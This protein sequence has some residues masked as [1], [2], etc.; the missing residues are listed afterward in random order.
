VDI[1][2]LLL[3]LAFMYAPL[4]RPPMEQIGPNLY[5]GSDPTMREICA[6]HEK[7]FKTIISIRTNA[8]DK[9]RKLCEKLGMRWVNIKTGVFLLPTDDQFDQFRAIIN[10]PENRPCLVS[11]ELGMDRVGVYIAAHRMA[12]ENWSERQ[13]REEFRTHHQKRWW[14][15]FRKYQQLV[16]GYAERR[17]GQYSAQVPGVNHQYQAEALPR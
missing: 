5:R 17:K 13:M 10:E 6:L 4:V 8:E 9:K 7:G 15:I 11:C 3:Q 2:T 16:V 1:K 12:D 14:P